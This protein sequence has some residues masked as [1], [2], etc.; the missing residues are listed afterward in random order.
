MTLK[1]PL[2]ITLLLTLS[3]C[4]GSKKADAGEDT[5]AAGS[6]T[7]VTEQAADVVAPLPD[8]VYESA[9]AV[10]YKVEIPDT[11]VSG[12]I[13]SFADMYAD[14]PGS[15]MFRKGLMRQADFGGR[16]SGRPSEIIVDWVFKTDTDNRETKF[17]TWGGGSGW[18][19]QPLYIN[20]PDSCVEH[21]CKA[22]V[23]LT[24]N[25]GKQ[26]I[27][28]GS[29]ACQVYF[30]NFETG[31]ASRPSIPTHNPIKGT[32]SLDPTLNGNLYVGQGVPAEE[33]FGAMVI[34]LYKHRQTDFTGRDPKAQRGWGAYDSSPVRVGQFL[35]RPGENGTIYKYLVAPGRLTLHSA[36]RYTVAGA[37][38]GIESSMS[39]Y[40][41][42][43]FTADNHGNILAVNLET[44]R[45]VWRYTLGDDTDATPVLA[46]EDG[47]P[48]L[49]V[50][51]EIDRQNSGTARFVKLD[52][53]NGAEVWKAETPGRRIDINSKH[54]DGG[55]YATALLG[56]GNCKDLVFANCVTNL[57]GQNGEFVAFNRND[58]SIVYRTRL[59]HYSWSSPVGFINEND[60]LFVVTGDTY[61]NIYLIN[62]IDGKIIYT[63][64]VGNNFESSPVVVGN[65]LVVG[66]RGNSI[67]KMTLK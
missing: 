46:V 63:K 64:A 19:G 25:F 50:G 65:S 38:P 33:P 23:P 22:G 10:K 7:I 15:L 8:T 32:A 67:F 13:S 30:I 56:Y 55:F 3:A 45:P 59:K 6:D 41:N 20:W 31:K 11:A 5:A 36:L 16:V 62:G 42:Y 18:T 29:L 51:C 12:A 53:L 39:V 66:S 26:E 28:V 58:G 34:D 37:A 27:I 14:A 54:F 49:Y 35:I 2:Y 17:G 21:F 61:G 4:G 9:S 44:M 24:D 43:G 57:D 47:K 1:K 48:Y 60:E 52:A 40:R